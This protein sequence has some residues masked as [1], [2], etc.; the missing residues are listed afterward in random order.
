MRI[1]APRPLLQALAAAVA[2][3]AFG[4]PAW[5]E[6]TFY[7]NDGFEGR[8]H[9]SQSQVRNLNRFGFN[10]RA[11]SVV[12]R[13]D[14]WQICADVNYGGRCMVLRPG[15]Y[16]SLS[17]MGMEDRISSARAV[18]RNARFEDN[19]YAPEPLVAQDYRRRNRE[20]LFEAPVTAVRAVV[21]SSGQRC[22]VE[23]QNVTEERADNRVP[24]AILGAVIG[25]ILGHQVGGGT[26]KDIATAG[27]VV[28]GAVV[29]SNLARNRD[30]TVSGT[31][32]VQRC[33]ATPG[34]AHPEYWDVT[35]RF[36]NKDHTVQLT[37][38]PGATIT[39]NREGEPRA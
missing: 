17:S 19:Q 6:I 39:V 36:R 31:R 38:P 37:R 18:R 8:S 14:N 28:A 10:D 33:V 13:T 30:G 5:A 16:P 32:D 12:V 1:P 22:W 4:G 35:Y 11:S 15:Q 25:G 2:V 27:G 24:G 23:R 29:G 34:G 9:N 7:A 21:A 26:G 3:L 20:R